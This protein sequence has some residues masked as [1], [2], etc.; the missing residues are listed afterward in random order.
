LLRE[1]VGDAALPVEYGGS[2]PFVL[3]H[4]IQRIDDEFERQYPL[5]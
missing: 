5:N 3:P 2:N 4:P 1:T